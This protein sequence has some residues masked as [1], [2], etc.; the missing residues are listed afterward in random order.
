MLKRDTQCV[1]VVTRWR[2]RVTIAAVATQQCVPLYCG[3]QQYKE[4]ECC[5]GNARMGSI[6]AIV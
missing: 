2:V 5:Y 1:Y 3:C 4:F 6:W